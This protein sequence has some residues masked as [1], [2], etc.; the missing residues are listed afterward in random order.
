[1]PGNRRELIVIAG[2]PGAGKS[3]VSEHLANLFEPSALVA[4]DSFFAMIKQGYILP[5]LPQSR[6]QNTVVVEAA[7]AAAGRLTDICSVVYDGVLGPW[8][9]PT[10]VR[11]TGLP[12]I[13]YVILLPPLEVCLERLQGRV[14]HG[15]SDLSVTRDLY[16][17]FANAAV[18]R[19]HLITEPGD[20]PAAL[21][22]LISRQLDD[23]RFRY[24]A[25]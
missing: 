18:E 15:F 8:L 20:H 12:D 3:S 11:G 25:S 23:G 10:F 5:W 9:L 6:R 19:R 24:S 7:A 17:Q 16:E 2:P 13:Q 1:L 14:E 22:E 4:G 21:A